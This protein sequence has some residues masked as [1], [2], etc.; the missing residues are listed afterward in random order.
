MRRF[1]VLTVVALVALLI[2]TTTCRDGGTTA[3]SVTSYHGP[4]LHGPLFPQGP[5]ATPPNVAPSASAG[6]DATLECAS[7]DGSTLALD[8]SRSADSDGH[9]VAFEWFENGKLVATGATPSLTL[10]LGVHS[11]ILRVTDDKGGTN[12]DLV[13][14]TVRD[15]QAPQV[16]MT[17]SPT[18]LWPPNHTMRLVAQNVG[19]VDVCDATPALSVVITSNEPINGLGDGDTSPDWSVETNG[20]ATMSAWVRAERSGLGTGRVYTIAAS[21]TDHS[22]NSASRSATVAVPHNQ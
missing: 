2:A 18:T 8:G 7:H 12:D 4:S 20:D 15:T 14:V 6:E 19:A 17:V 13:V 21:A 16:L 11:L 9:I 22:G 5:S 1:S 3:P 10:P